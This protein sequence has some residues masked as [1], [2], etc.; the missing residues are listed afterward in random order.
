MEI[1]VN[2]KVFFYILLVVDK[3][4]HICCI[5]IIPS[6]V[7]Y[8]TH[9]KQGICVTMVTYMWYFM[10]YITAHDY[11]IQRERIN[12]LDI[13]GNGQFGDVHKGVY[14]EKVNF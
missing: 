12:L 5:F 4:G 14:R 7:I 9:K 1:H 3:L 6:R 11:E 13:L 10:Y 8:C 2:N